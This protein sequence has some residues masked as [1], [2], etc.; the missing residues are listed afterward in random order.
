VSQEPRE[1][2]TYE[3]AGVDISKA[4]QALQRMKPH[5]ESTHDQYV[6]GG[7]G[8]FAPVVDI[9]ALAQDL[10]I[11]HP[12]LLASVDGPGTIPLI[13][14][15]ARDFV[16]E[17]FVPLGYNV[18]AHCFADVACGGGRPI[19]FLDCIDS[20]DV[21]PDVHEEIVKGMAEAC[22][23]IG[24]RLIGGE[25][26]QLPGLIVPGQTNFAGF[27][28]A[29]AEKRQ[30]INP[31]RKIH[32]GQ[33]VLG[34]ESKGIHLNGLS[35]YRKIVFDV[36]GMKPS[37]ILPPT[38]KTIAEEVLQ[39]QPNYALVVIQELAQVIEMCGNS[40]ITGGGLIDN[41]TRNLPDGCKVIIDTS[42]WGVPPLFRWL[43]EKGNV[44]LDDARRTWNIGIGFVQILMNEWFLRKAQS[45]VQEVLGLRSWVIGEVVEGE[46]GV[47]FV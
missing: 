40:N 28:I 9:T 22:R 32:P 10:G 19:A 35:L 1:E 37:D 6:L 42:K 3:K 25:T 11:K 13:A 23:E 46:K 18:A 33:P 44:P 27:V 47:E 24:C 43:I 26:A 39:R 14:Q 29:L 15:M 4:E 41:I 36:L 17:S 38:R 30:L 31:Q 2:L 16:P 34:I 5:C 8:P 21:N 20:T 45:L 7:I 12:V